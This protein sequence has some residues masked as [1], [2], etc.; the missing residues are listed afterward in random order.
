MTFKYF[1]GKNVIKIDG[2]RIEKIG[3]KKKEHFLQYFS[4]EEYVIYFNRI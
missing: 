1:Q 2:Y 3:R 4:M